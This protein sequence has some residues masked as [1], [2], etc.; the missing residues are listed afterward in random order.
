LS[1]K[2]L[3]IYAAITIR[4]VVVTRRTRSAPWLCLRICEFHPRFRSPHPPAH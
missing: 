3:V 2:L 4:F 1:V